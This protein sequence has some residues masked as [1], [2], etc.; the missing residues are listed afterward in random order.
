MAH[1]IFIDDTGSMA[2]YAEKVLAMKFSRRVKLFAWADDVWSIRGINE[3]TFSNGPSDLG[4]VARFL[5]NQRFGFW[6][7]LFPHRITVITDELHYG[8]K[9]PK[10]WKVIDVTQ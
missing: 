2:A 5:A 7:R 3:L 8:I 1:L 6:R 9:M 4:C 10:N